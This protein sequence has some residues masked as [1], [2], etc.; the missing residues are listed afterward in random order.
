MFPTENT[1]PNTLS[2]ISSCKKTVRQSSTVFPT[3]YPVE[4]SVVQRMRLQTFC[5]EGVD[6]HRKFVNVQKILFCS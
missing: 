2:G 3:E 4:K 1:T 5:T 6:F